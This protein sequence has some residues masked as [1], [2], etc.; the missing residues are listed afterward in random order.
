MGRAKLHSEDSAALDA[1]G[2]YY[3]PQHSTSSRSSNDGGGGGG[4]AA[5]GASGA[6]GAG[7]EFMGCASG[8]PFA[9]ILLGRG[10][11]K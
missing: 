7:R 6:F 8:A 5:L 1:L 10:I 11:I 2:A 3:V 4:A 9:S